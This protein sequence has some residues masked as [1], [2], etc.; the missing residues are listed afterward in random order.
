MT[1]KKHPYRFGYFWS[2]HRL[3]FHEQRGEVP[4]PHV[5]EQR[6][7]PEQRSL[8]ETPR[9]VESLV[10][11]VNRRIDGARVAAEGL[12]TEFRTQLKNNLALFVRAA[13]DRHR[14]V[15]RDHS[16]SEKEFSA[17]AGRF[18]RNWM[19]LL[20]GWQEGGDMPKRKQKRR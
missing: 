4:H 11:D 13:A 12:P 1:H 7:T 5:P 18:R 16:L 19:G 14:L 15:D 9:D 20:Q 2:E 6:D 8:S 3:V 10:T 17:L